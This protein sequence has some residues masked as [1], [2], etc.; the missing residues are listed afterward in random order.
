M[1]KLIKMF[2]LL[3]MALGVF[4]L[5]MEPDQ[6]VAADS[7][8]S[9]V[10]HKLKFNED[11][12]L[13]DLI[14]TGQE[15][16][17]DQDVPFEGV[18]F[19][20]YD[21]TDEYHNLLKKPG[22]K[23]E[24]AIDQIIS[25]YQMLD[26]EKITQ[27]ITDANGQI[28]FSNLT[29]GRTY[30]LIE[31]PLENVVKGQNLVVTI[32]RHFVG[33][34]HVY[35]KNVV[36]KKPK[37]FKKQF[38]KVDLD[39]KNP[40]AGAQ[41]IVGIKN[42]G[43]LTNDGTWLKTIVKSSADAVDSNLKILTSDAEGHFTIDGLKA[44]TYYIREIRAPNGYELLQSNVEFEVVAGEYL[45]NPDTWMKVFNR[46]ESPPEPGNPP[47]EPEIP[48]DPDQEVVKPGIDVVEEIDKLIQKVLPKTGEAKGFGILG[49]VL[50]VI[51]LG[52]FIGLN[53][54]KRKKNE[55]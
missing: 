43:Y 3:V 24:T 15:L 50:V 19:T 8:T 5:H 36:K 49:V 34:Y 47:E 18:E 9:I 33:E 12:K 21:V 39:D 16:S 32:P 1:N 4:A 44:G 6:V 27:E 11:E 17:L 40:L 37:L 7:G 55:K 25:Q 23:A 29:P 38:I 41:F 10:V 45:D 48:E 22:L 53:K 20:L 35:P 54:E 28:N 14:N 46:K 31:S 13:P 52:Y 2:T 42:E 51:S 30:L 26:I